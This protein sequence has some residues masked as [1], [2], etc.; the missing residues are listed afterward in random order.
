M[1]GGLDYPRLRCRIGKT[2]SVTPRAASLIV[3]LPF[4]VLKQG[5]GVITLLFEQVRHYRGNVRSL[6][7]YPMTD[8]CAMP[9]PLS[10][11]NP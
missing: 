9:L 11:K 5:F 8:E 6:V 3:K 7:T 4:I 2:W 10:H 1:R